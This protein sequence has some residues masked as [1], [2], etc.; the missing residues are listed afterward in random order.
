MLLFLSLFTLSRQSKANVADFL[1]HS[2]GNISINFGSL[3]L[4]N[5]GTVFS[6]PNLKQRFSLSIKNLIAT[7]SF[8]PFIRSN[9]MHL[10]GGLKLTNSVF[11]NFKSNAV[12]ISR[13]QALS[14]QHETFANYTETTR[15]YN[16]E[17][18][19][20]IA[21]FSSCTFI[22]CTALSNGT[23]AT[24]SPS[25]SGGALYFIDA[26]NVSISSCI[27]EDCR[28][29]YKGGAILIKRCTGRTDINHCRFLSCASCYGTAIQIEASGQS[30][31]SFSYF[32][33]S[34]YVNTT[35]NQSA[36]TGTIY[37]SRTALTVSDCS[38]VQTRR[39]SRFP[40]NYAE[41]FLYNID[42]SGYTQTASLTAQNLCTEVTL[43]NLVNQSVD[44]YIIYYSSPPQ[45]PTV[46]ISD[47]L[48]SNAV[49]SY[50]YFISE[51]Q[52]RT[53]SENDAASCSL[54]TIIT[55]PPPTQ[56]PI[57]EPPPQPTEN[58]T[59]TP[60]DSDSGL[61]RT[62]LICAIAIPVIIVVIIII[63]LIV[64]FVIM[65]DRRTA[66]NGDEVEGDEY[67]F[68]AA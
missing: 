57:I 41:I 34:T 52:Q 68:P 60:D 28:S 65:K 49:G 9:A 20:Y 59:Q 38:F 47:S 27:F 55:P 19:G 37:C 32:S 2:R 45:N 36:N 39:H 1:P 48:N 31:I 29:F 66:F 17:E 26:V 11:K 54:Y 22:H 3:T 21:E 25:N 62:E 40:T 6:I 46:T 53:A 64:I 67:A 24:T 15:F 18:S 51:S 61:T 56:T 44:Y 35:E 33:Q 10:N 23:E 8:E 43:S 30:S 5:Q 12:V 58:I 16:K 4:A 13:E 42:E 63:V 50:L 14:H 7:K